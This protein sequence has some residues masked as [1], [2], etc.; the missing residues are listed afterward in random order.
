MSTTISTPSMAIGKRKRPV[1]SYAEDDDLGGLL[2]DMKG[3]EANGL[4]Q[5]SGDESGNDDRTYSTRKVSSYPTPPQDKPS[6]A[7]KESNQEEGLAEEESEDD[8]R[9]YGT[10][11][12]AIP[13][14]GPTA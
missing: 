13:V 14:H 10:R 5:S 7:A 1:V 6:D 9:S 2:G 8:L 4:D 11:Y 12:Q 3:H